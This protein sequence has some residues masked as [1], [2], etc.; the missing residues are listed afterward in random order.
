MAHSTVVSHRVARA[1]LAVAVV[2]GA[3]SWAAGQGAAQTAPSINLKPDCTDRLKPPW[4]LTASGTMLVPGAPVLVT[5]DYGGAQPTSFQQTTD[6]GGGY[7]LDIF[8]RS[9]GPPPPDGYRVRAVQPRRPND[10]VEARFRV[11]CPPPPTTSPPTSGSTTSS[12]TTSTTSTTA[13]PPAARPELT[14]NPGVGR[15]GEVVQV[16]GTGFAP[17]AVALSWDRAG[18]AGAAIADG[19]GNFMQ[20]VVVFGHTA[21]GARTLLAASGATAATAPFL[22]VPGSQQPSGF[23]TRR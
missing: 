16:I 3:L 13:P 18:P 15:A 17:G 23:F 20:R 12:S 11:P 21:F 2:S 4:S 9:A 19:S 7:Q 22:V 10:P 8:I 6:K 14:I 1:L 5:F